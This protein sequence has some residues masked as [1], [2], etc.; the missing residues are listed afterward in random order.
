MKQSPE[1]FQIRGA[2]FE[3]APT[4]ITTVAGLRLLMAAAHH[5]K[6]TQAIR[7]HIKVKKIASGFGEEEFLLPLVCNLALGRCDLNDITELRQDKELTKLVFGRTKLPSE[8][9]LAEHL[10]AY[11]E[12]D[13][14]G[15]KKVNASLLEYL[16]LLAEEPDGRISLDFDSSCFE[17]YGTQK[18]QMGRHYSGT[19]GF[20]PVFAFVGRNGFA[21]NSLLRPGNN[22]DSNGLEPFLNETLSLLPQS[23]RHRLVARFDSG[24]YSQQNMTTLHR[25]Q[26]DFIVKARLCDTLRTTV[27]EELEAGR[28]TVAPTS[29]G[30]D[31]YGEFT[32]QPKGW[33]QPLRYCFCLQ[34]E[35][36][37]QNGQLLLIPRRQDLIVATT[38]GAEEATAQQVFEGY[39]RRGRAEQFIKELKGPLNLEQLPTQS[40][41][42]N[43]VML[44]A[45]LLA[46]NLLLLLEANWEGWQR[47][48]G[49]KEKADGI[50]RSIGR[51]S[52][53]T[54]Q[55]KLLFCAATIIHHARTV[56]LK[57]AGWWLESI[58]P[59]R[60]L[61][62][63]KN[64][65]PKPG[66]VLAEG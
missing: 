13:L 40:F 48:P 30:G 60:I 38:L 43:E 34:I 8:R 4:A 49:K 6:L 28:T 1:N 59:N 17:Q 26:I 52:L 19:M 20:N 61:E 22:K 63:I 12:S 65:R 45:G 29:Y 5:V 41:R 66:P 36:K 33:P 32:Y 44:Q 62:R 15:L 2:R 54:V 55:E 16:E 27:T 57:V 9:R 3:A 24:F 31:V 21:L 10:A 7:S 58:Q 46:Y 37:E 50:E 64:L 25:E 39:R 14:S 56:V 23:L 51:R 35:E 11:K 53:R 47:K 18:E 42:A